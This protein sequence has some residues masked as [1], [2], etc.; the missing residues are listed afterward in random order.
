[1]SLACSSLV[2]VAEDAELRLVALLGEYSNKSEPSS[3]VADCEACIAAGDAGKLLMTIVDDQD[4]MQA[5]LR[6]PS[7]DE[8]V[9]CFSLLVAL[10]ERAAADDTSSSSGSNKNKQQLVSVSKLADSIL[11]PS[12]TSAPTTD[13]ADA[14]AVAGTDEEQC[15]RKIRLLSVIYNLRSS[16]E[17]KCDMLTRMIATAGDTPQ[18]AEL[19]LARHDASTLGRLLVADENEQDHYYRS[20][21]SSSNPAAGGMTTSTTTPS[22]PRIV[23][24]MDAW[25]VSLSNRRALYK[26][27]ASVMPPQDT[28]KQRFQLLLVETYTTTTTTDDKAAAAADNKE[29]L[30]AAKEA[31][32]GA[33]RDPIALF[34]HQRN[35]LNQP[36]IQALGAADDS[37]DNNKMLFGLLKVFQEGKLQDYLDFIKTN[38][39]NEAAIL[40]QWGLNP[41]Q[42]QG[43]IR[44]LSLCSLATEHEEIPYAIIAETLQIDV[45]AVES[46]VIAAVSSGLLQ[47]KMDQLAQKVMVERCV[48]RRFD[49]EQWKVLQGRL[50]TWKNNVG[51]I[52]ASLKQQQSAAVS[53]N[54]TTTTTTSP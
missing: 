27:I 33:I 9:G 35:L 14:A 24:M 10:L 1:M 23:Q 50:Q 20:S 15:Q 37:K 42:C 4:A 11:Q 26:T 32:I 30:E 25:N 16:V 12:T 22:V 51:S 34:A 28:R 13:A 8:A 7:A 17:E 31:A 48:F 5:F 45:T 29:R 52:L 49:L 46:Q 47:A 21:S 39:G 19:F 38:G 2:N 3:F 44:I 36:A 41:N 54:A 53:A 43:N 6:I 40:Q 18:H